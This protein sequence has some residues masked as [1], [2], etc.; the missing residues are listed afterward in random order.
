M[1][2]SIHIKSLYVSVWNLSRWG[3]DVTEA[4]DQSGLVFGPGRRAM[5][6]AQAGLCRGAVKARF[7]GC[8]HCV[9]G[10]WVVLGMHRLV[11]G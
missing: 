2:L 8:G 9:V 10:I 5:G 4:E 3:R 6:R 7:V 11:G 1:D